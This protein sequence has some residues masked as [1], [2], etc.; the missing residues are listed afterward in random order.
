LG[1]CAAGGACLDIFGSYTIPE[2]VGYAHTWLSQ[3]AKRTHQK[4]TFLKSKEIAEFSIFKSSMLI[5]KG[6]QEISMFAVVIGV[7]RDDKVVTNIFDPKFTVKE[8]DTLLV[9]GDPANLLVLEK[10]A[11]AL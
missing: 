2:G 6:L 3:S 10:E 11:K 4:T 9:L 1:G 8:N 7:V 5:G